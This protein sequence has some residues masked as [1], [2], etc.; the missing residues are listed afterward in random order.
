MRFIK[1]TLYITDE[2]SFLSLENENIVIKIGDDKKRVPLV[3]L[4]NIISFSYSGVTVPLMQ[5][6]SSRKIGLS[7][8]D[9]HSNEFV[10]INGI[11]HGN[12]L[13]R[14]EQYRITSDEELSCKY[15][16]TIIAS[17]IA[18]NVSVL[19]RLEKNKAYSPLHQSSNI[20]RDTKRA[21]EKLSNN[22]EFLL[23]NEYNRE[24]IFG[25]EGDCAREYFKVLGKH[26]KSKEIAETWNG[27]TKKPPRDPMNAVLSLLYVFVSQDYRNALYCAGLD[28]Y[29]GFLH[30]TKSGKPS[31]ALDMMEEYRAVVDRFVITLFNKKQLTIK[32]FEYR[33]DTSVLLKD[34]AR[35]KLITEWQT[36]KKKELVHPL[37]KEKIT[38]ELVPYIQAS[39]LAQTIRGDYDCYL[40]FLLGSTL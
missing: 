39:L 38:Y 3:V 28:P 9:K 14:K 37:T 4:Q 11:L 21:I 32:D 25:I 12:V 6:I 34:K 22:A 24:S 15:A 17:K 23:S 13:L 35:K 8:I 26:I 36:F 2:Q 7:F 29:L 16:Q 10:E 20:N 31:L 19:K 33:L 18:N 27:R 1:N 40:P 30:G 5:E